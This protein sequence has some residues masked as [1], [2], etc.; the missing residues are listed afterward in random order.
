MIAIAMLIHRLQSAAC[1]AYKN[2]TLDS[3]AAVTWHASFDCG[4]FEH[5]LAI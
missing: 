2:V 5:R 4:S 3:N 1:R